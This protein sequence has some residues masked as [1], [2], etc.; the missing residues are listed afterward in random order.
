MMSGTAQY[1]AQLNADAVV[2]VDSLYHQ[3]GRAGM[4]MVIASGAAKRLS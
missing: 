2:C 4:L 1:E 3:A